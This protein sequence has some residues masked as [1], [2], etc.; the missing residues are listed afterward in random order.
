MWRR[1]VAWCHA[2]QLPLPMPPARVTTWLTWQRCLASRPSAGVRC[3]R[4]VAQRVL[5]RRRVPFRGSLA[6]LPLLTHPPPLPYPVTVPQRRLALDAEP[7]AAAATP[8]A[9]TSRVKRVRVVQLQLSFPPEGSLAAPGALAAV[10]GVL[11]S[12]CFS[13][14]RGVFRYHAHTAGRPCAGAPRPRPATAARARRRV[15]GAQRPCLRAP[16]APAGTTRASSQ[17]PC[18][19]PPTTRP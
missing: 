18:P 6:M 4:C 16:G 12:T 5:T 7:A 8:A 17:R 13:L 2:Y 9:T 10:F 3:P 15:E 19:Q 1:C 11:F 14:R